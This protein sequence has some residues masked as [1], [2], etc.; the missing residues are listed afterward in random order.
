MS[1]P[2]H[3]SLA[4][5]G[6][7]ARFDGDVHGCHDS[8]A[9]GWM[10]PHS[11]CALLLF[12]LTL[13]STSFVDRWS[14]NSILIDVA[15]KMVPPTDAPCFWLSVEMFEQQSSAQRSNTQLPPCTSASS[16]IIILP[17]SPHVLV[18]MRALPR[19]KWCSSVIHTTTILGSA[20]R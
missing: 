4:T 3:A 15:K 1:M 2:L 8:R 11:D 5:I 19:V 7:Y 9:E 17:L 13:N 14:Y 12:F 16:E 18:V 10:A 20:K 6:N